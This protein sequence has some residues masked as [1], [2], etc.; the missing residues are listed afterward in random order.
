MYLSVYVCVMLSCLLP[1]K[2]HHVV[3]LIFEAAFQ[4]AIDLAAILTGC[5]W[6]F[7]YCVTYRI[8]NNNTKT[9][10]LILRLL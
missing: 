1:Q 7:L 4:W 10:L 6:N 5:G 2:S 8:I 9:I 3:D